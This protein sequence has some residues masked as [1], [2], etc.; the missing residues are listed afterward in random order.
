MN[1][2][3]D[4]LVYL[5]DTLVKN[6]AALVLTGYVE[7]I[8]RTLLVD[9]TLQAGMKEGDRIE[10]T[11]QGSLTKIEREG[12]KD[13]NEFD[14]NN[15]FTH[16]H[17]DKD[18]DARQLVREQLQ[19]Q[20]TFTTFVLNGNLMSYFN[21]H[22]ELHHKDVTDIENDNIEAGDM[23]E[24]EGTITNSCVAT[25]VETLIN[26][27]DAFGCEYLNELTKDCKCKM[28]FEAFSKMLACLKKT[29]DCN[30]TQDLIMEC[31]SGKAVLTVNKVNFLNSSC[32]IY[33][34]INCHCKVVGK[35]VKTCSSDEDT[36]S[37]LR[38]T[39]QEDFYEK[40]FDM[41]KPLLECMSNNGIMIP[42]CPDLRI[43]E[44]AIQIMPLNIYM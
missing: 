14:S 39:G 20:K 11:N 24:I 16:Y 27:I 9:K 28:K 17:L 12:F 6:L 21:E 30:N 1:N 26:L 35:V 23:I 42:K 7:T 10:S 31:G 8:T 32:N 38:K 3:F 13:R 41:S 40:F 19:V 4:V 33:D 18:I 22:N 15:D 34:K 43:N 25:Y 36:I 44:C 2:P 29:L 37:L 5:D